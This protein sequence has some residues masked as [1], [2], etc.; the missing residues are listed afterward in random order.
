MEVKS[1]IFCTFFMFQ[2]DYFKAGVRKPPVVSKMK[3]PN[4]YKKSLNFILKCY[5][6]FRFQCR[7]LQIGGQKHAGY[8]KNDKRI[9]NFYENKKAR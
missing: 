5:T 2:C 6:F 7:Y 9:S 3:R 4:L 8:Y 1:K